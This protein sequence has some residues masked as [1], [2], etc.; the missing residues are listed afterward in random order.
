MKS[1]PMLVGFV[2]SR[3][4]LHGFPHRGYHTHTL[5]PCSQTNVAQE[6]SHCLHQIA[7]MEDTALAATEGV[8]T[9]AI[10]VIVVSFSSD[11]NRGSNI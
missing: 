5:V 11:A 10:G 8:E 9:E 4:R 2:L 7:S 6:P 1:K 3:A